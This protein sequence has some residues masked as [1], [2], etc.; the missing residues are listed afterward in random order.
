[1]KIDFIKLSLNIFYLSV[2]EE[3]EVS[4]KEA[5][6]T[7]IKAMD[8]KGEVVFDTTKSDG[9]FKKTAS[10]AKLRKYLPDFKFTP[11]DKGMNFIEVI[12][13]IPDNEPYP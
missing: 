2:G 10:N 1:V 9:Q 12:Y 8:F 13:I 5:A 6:E 4:I 11:F 3:D 7:V